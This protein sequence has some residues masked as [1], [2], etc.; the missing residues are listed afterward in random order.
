M[1][2]SQSRDAVHEFVYHVIRC[3]VRE[4]NEKNEAKKIMEDL[5]N[6]KVLGRIDE[7]AC[8]LG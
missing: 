8:S 3:L 1:E 2:T 6:E 4:K 7:L 5:W